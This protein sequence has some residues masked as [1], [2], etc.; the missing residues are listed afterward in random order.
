ML[1]RAPWVLPRHYRTI[2]V[3]VRVPPA[4]QRSPSAFPLLFFPALQGFCQAFPLIF[5]ASRCSYHCR[6]GF[7]LIPFYRGGCRA[8]KPEQTPMAWREPHG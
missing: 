7:Y 3:S 6:E 4:H 5:L 2:E 8:K 1:L